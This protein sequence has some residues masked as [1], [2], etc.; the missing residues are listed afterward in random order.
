[1]RK[2]IA[3][4]L[5]FAFAYDWMGYWIT[6]KYRQFQIK[7]SIKEKIAEGI[8]ISSPYLVIFQ[9]HKQETDKLIWESEGEEFVYEDCWYDVVA[10]LDK[11]D[12]LIYYAIPDK[13]EEFLVQSFKKNIENQLDNKKINLH[14]LLLMEY[15][16]PTNYS[17][18]PLLFFL[19]RELY[20]SFYC[21]H[22]FPIFLEITSPPPQSRLSYFI[23]QSFT[24]IHKIPIFSY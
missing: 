7:T 24:T 6:F 3:I 8:A 19:D 16:I 2:T 15:L 4:I 13:N 18:Q 17:F 9:I 12:S 21:L 14:K 22:F 1:V 20:H 23:S 11:N 10:T 5:L